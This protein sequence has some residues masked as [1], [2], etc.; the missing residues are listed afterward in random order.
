MV[1]A[2]KQGRAACLWTLALA[3]AVMALPVTAA[4]RAVAQAETGV[5]CVATFADLNAN[6]VRDEG[7]GTLAGVNVNLSTGGAIIATHITEEGETEHCFE[8][9]LRGIYTVSFTESPLYR[10]TTPREGT[11]ALEAGQRLTIDAFGAFPV[12]PAGLRA[13]IIAQA[14]AAQRDEPLD[15]STRLLLATGGAAVVMMFMVGLGAV[16]LG[17]LDWRRQRRQRRQRQHRPLVPPP[18]TDWLRPPGR[19]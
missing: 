17:L 18:P 16:T 4:P 6:G 7:E 3:L 2:L 19:A 14:Q 15:T 11:F 12:G 13:E 1:G 8:R 10:I 5:I 9:L